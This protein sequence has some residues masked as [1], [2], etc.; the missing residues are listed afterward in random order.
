ML[1]R[2]I[3]A[4]LLISASFASAGQLVIELN[5]TV[6]AG[7]IGR[8]ADR[9]IVA[10]DETAPIGVVIQG[11]QPVNLF[12]S[13][14]VGGSLMGI[15]KRPVRP[16][17]PDRE[18]VL[19]IGQLRLLQIGSALQLGMHM[20]LLEHK[21]NGYQ[22]LH[23][24][25]TTL[26][27]TSTN[28]KDI[29]PMLAQ[30][31]Q[32]CLDTFAE[33]L[34]GNRTATQ[35]ME[36]SE[37]LEPMVAHTSALPVWHNKE[38]PAGVYHTFLDMIHDRPDTMDIRMRDL[39]R[40]LHDEQL[41]RLRQMDRDIR[42]SIWG[43]TDGT[44]IYKSIGEEFVRLERHNDGFIARWQAPAQVDGAAMMLGG[45]MGG[46]MGAAIV[47]GLSSRPGQLILYELAPLS[48]D[49]WPASER[50][51]RPGFRCMHIFHF[52]RYAK[53]D[54]DI[55]V[56]LEDAATATLNKGHW[57]PVEP[58]PRMVQAFAT[59]R[60]QDGPSVR[61]PIDTQAKRTTVHLIDL[62]ANGELSVKQLPEQMASKI[63]E[64]LKKE[65]RR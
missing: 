12:F 49:L 28:K 8:V 60:I 46:L 50:G 63:I 35:A 4:S 23:A 43:F 40:G 47:G 42:R 22:R 6:R 20:E 5:D 33:A 44:H 1:P 56:N 62:K 21:E 34:A 11:E 53:R 36:A 26:T 17:G 38:R 18:V 32:E 59:V 31:F 3:L 54:A 19:K 39:V 13:K 41:V 24:H 64:R 58:E 51:Q 37:A 45:L 48:G 57:T 52:S 7:P 10:F 2:T 55:L 9:M 30:A 25:G 65:D 29:A 14:P 61:V 16:E 15:L 27:R